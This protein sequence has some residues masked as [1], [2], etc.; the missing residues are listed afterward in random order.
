MIRHKKI[1]GTELIAW[2][3]IALNSTLL[4]TPLAHGDGNASS[5]LT[6]DQ[7]LSEATLNSPQLQLAKA[8]EDEAKGHKNEA[9]SGFLPVLSATAY[10]LTNT[11]YE[12]FAAQI[13]PNET[14]PFPEV[15]PKTSLKFSLSLPLFDGLRNV[16]QY[17]ASDAASEASS[18]SRAWQEFVLS[19]NVK[20]TFYRAL[21]A[22]L[23]A[24]VADENIRTLEDHYAHVQARQKGGIATSYDVLRVEVQLDE[25]RSQ[26]I[27]ADDNVVIERK[28]LARVMGIPED[29]RPVA[30]ELPVPEEAPRI[31]R[32]TAE[33]ALQARKDLEALRLQEKAADLSDTAAKSWLVPAVGLMADYEFYDNADY[34]L[35][36]SSPYHN[37]YDFGFYLRWN[38]F[39]GGAS[40]ARAQQSGAQHRQAQARLEI[41]K[42]Q[43]PEGLETW[44][45]R[46]H[47]GVSLYETAVSDIRK[48][49]ISVRQAQEGFR[50]GVRTVSEQLDAQLDLFRSRANKV[51][52][53]LTAAEA[54]IQ[55]E[56]TVGRKLTHDDLI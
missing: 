31:S 10:H 15:L 38:L 40:I 24:E 3:A 6:L 53:Q 2:V 7:A 49:E 13:A 43:L 29:S 22:Q 5:S 28:R 55:L 25:A 18:E 19:Q 45:R 44:K 46:Y 16:N 21:A 1:P 54:L 51:N 8:R 50:Q 33:N 12:T 52:A 47:Y 11:K 35:T 27:Q 14:L 39:D 48:S 20:D 56:L 17:R 32:L 9:L 34:D 30:G 42:Q 26:K 36:S 41:E 4:F 23:L 37:A